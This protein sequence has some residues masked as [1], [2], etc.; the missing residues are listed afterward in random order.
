[1]R[2][3]SAF[4]SVAARN[5]EDIVLES[6]HLSV[7]IAKETTGSAPPHMRRNWSTQVGHDTARGA[8][9]SFAMRQRVLAFE[10]NVSSFRAAT[11]RKADQQDGSSAPTMPTLRSERS[12]R[13]QPGWDDTANTRVRTYPVV[14]RHQMI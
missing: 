13:R 3:V 8:E 6:K 9:F 10:D 2:P 12:V 11:L 5:D 14:Q 4:R 7:F 1:M